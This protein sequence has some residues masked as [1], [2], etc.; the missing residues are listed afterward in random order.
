MNKVTFFGGVVAALAVLAGGSANAYVNVPT[1][2]PQPL[3][4][5]EPIQI[6]IESGMEHAIFEAPGDTMIFPRVTRVGQSIRVEVLG[7]DY[8]NT[9]PFVPM[10]AT[11]WTYTIGSF[12]AG[13]YSVSL[14][15]ASP[16][17]DGFQYTTLHTVPAIIRGQG[18]PTM[19]PSGGWQSALILSLGLVLVGIAA[20]R[21]R[22][23][24]R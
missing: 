5:N 2:S 16:I 3:E 7:V 23:A 15:M 20:V 6:R 8:T 14:V 21:K 4:A 17:P 1:L 10:P 13:A 12:P 11:T 9:S 24:R 19:L 18:E 22:V